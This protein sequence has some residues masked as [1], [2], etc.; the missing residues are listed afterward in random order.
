MN[1]QDGF[2]TGNMTLREL[3]RVI[4]ECEAL[5]QELALRFRWKMRNGKPIGEI[6]DGE[7]TVWVT[8]Y[9]SK[10]F[11]YAY[12]YMVCGI[13]ER[14]T[15][16]KKERDIAASKKSDQEWRDRITE[17]RRQY[18]LKNYYGD[19]KAESGK[20]QDGEATDEI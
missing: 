2:D 8:E 20:F 13:H 17:A 11:H 5:S 15:R 9:I 12:A 4:R 7:K 6:L 19:L 10:Q 14:L 16:I 18:V 1:W 3:S